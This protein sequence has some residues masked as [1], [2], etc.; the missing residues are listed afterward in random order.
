MHAPQHVGGHEAERT[1]LELTRCSGPGVRPRAP[2]PSQASARPSSRASGTRAR[3]G[4]QHGPQRRGLAGSRRPAG[5]R[6]TPAVPSGGSQCSVRPRPACRQAQREPPRWRRSSSSPGP[7]G[8]QVAAAK[9]QG[10][11]DLQVAA[12]SSVSS[13][14]SMEAAA[15]AVGRVGRG[16]RPPAD[17]T[18]RWITFARKFPGVTLEQSPEVVTGTREERPVRRRLAA[19][20]LQRRR[21]GSPRLAA[22]G[23]R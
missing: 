11:G 4:T 22:P 17:G 18:C 10:L 16:C 14:V 3:R 15:R 13:T 21:T 19:L 20:H 5:P 7:A 23:S 12:A 1:P 6:A 9:P 8:A 2:A